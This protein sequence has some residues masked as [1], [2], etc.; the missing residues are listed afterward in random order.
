M[1]I[2]ETCICVPHSNHW[3]QNIL[4]RNMDMLK[5]KCIIY[6]FTEFVGEG[7]TAA[8]DEK[9]LDDTQESIWL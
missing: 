3:T 8:Y 7:K 1:V 9:K 6:S 2:N 5:C 4:H